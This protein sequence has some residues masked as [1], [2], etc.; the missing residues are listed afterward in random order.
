MLIGGAPTTPAWQEEIGAD[1]WA[2]TAAGA[3]KIAVKWMKEKGK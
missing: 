1:A 2:Q 3:A